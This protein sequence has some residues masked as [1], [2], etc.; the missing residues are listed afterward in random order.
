MIE[1][2]TRRRRVW[3]V[4]SAAAL[5]LLLTGSAAL[6]WLGYANYRLAQA[7][8]VPDVFKLNIQEVHS[9]V[10]R[11]ADIRTRAGNGLTVAMAAAAWGDL[12]LLRR[13]LAGGV[14]ANAAMDDGTTALILA[15][16]MV[17]PGETRVLLERGARPDARTTSGTTALIE[18]AGADM[19]DLMDQE[20]TL[21]LLLAA[22]ARIDDRDRDGLTPLMIAAR[23]K[24]PGAARVLLKA[25]ADPRTA[26][27]WA[28]AHWE[29]TRH[30]LCRAE[31]I[32]VIRSALKPK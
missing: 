28:E 10:R 13:A 8:A 26:L 2:S 20:E 22:G 6:F 5:L 29:S 18:A 17:R 12:P 3:E 27:G 24:K 21:T 30:A 9:W 25:G 19:V 32:Q 11:G 23:L 7:L 15:A 4:G 1:A 31:T 14:D 16:Q